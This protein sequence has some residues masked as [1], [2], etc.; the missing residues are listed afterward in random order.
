MV[1][2]LCWQHGALSAWLTGILTRG[3]ILRREETIWAVPLTF[4]AGTRNTRLHMSSSRG[5][6]SRAAAAQP[7]SSAAFDTSH[8]SLQ[9]PVYPVEKKC[10][11][12]FNKHS[13]NQMLLL[14][15]F[16]LDWVLIQYLLI[17]FENM[18]I[19]MLGCLFIPKQVLN[20]LLWLLT[21]VCRLV[22]HSLLI[23]AYY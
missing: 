15:D 2:W 4:Q 11:W 8:Y 5:E 10:M 13:V 21:V 12:K 14:Q 9:E 18:Y 16:F 1:I 20:F 19:V 6:T 17:G 23:F 3:E 7:I 22:V